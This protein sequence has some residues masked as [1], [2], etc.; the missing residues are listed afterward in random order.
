M[1]RL[2]SK[3]DSEGDSSHGKVGLDLVALDR[4]GAIQ[5]PAPV[6]VTVDWAERSC[7]PVLIHLG[8]SCYSRHLNP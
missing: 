5:P 7:G 4:D 2:P 8:L 3:G 6:R 1:K